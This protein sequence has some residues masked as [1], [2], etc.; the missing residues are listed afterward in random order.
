MGIVEQLDPIFKPKTVAIIGA[1]Y[2]PL[3]FGNWVT[4]TALRSKFQGKTY[5]VNPKITGFHNVKVY[6][7]I[8]DIPEKV[9]LVAI[10]V[11]ANIIPK[12]L[13]D[14]VEKG[15]KGAIIFSAGFREIGE[16][17]VKRE[18]EI[19]EVAK[20]GNIRIVGP[21]CMGVYNAAVGLNITIL[22]AEK[23]GEVG[24][25]TQSGGYGLDIFGTGMAKGINFSKFISVGDKI[26]VKDNEYLEYLYADPDTKVI[27]MYMEGIEKGREFFEIAK[28]ITQKKPIFAIKIGRTSAGGAAAKSHTGAMAGEDEIFDAAFKQAGIIRAY[29]VEELFDYVKAYLAQPLPKGNRVG[30]LVGS[31]GLGAAAVDKA[32]ELGLRVPTISE[33]NKQRLKEI[34]PEF[35]SYKNPIDFTASGSIGLFTNIDVLKQV[36]ADPNIDSWFFGFTGSGISGIDEI[37]GNFGPM[38]DQVDASVVMEGVN[39]P[40]VGSMDEDDKLIRPLLQK[41]F[42]VTLYSTPERA[43]RALAGLV[44][45]RQFLEEGRRAQKPIKLKADTSAVRKIVE[46]ALDERRADLTEVESKQILSAYQ[47]PTTDAYLAKNREEAAKCADKIGYPVVLKIVSPDIIHKSD[48][49]GVKLNLLNRNEVV[50]AFDQIIQNARKYK[51]KASILGVSVQKMVSQGIEVIVGIKDDPQFGP[52][53]MFGL[54]GILTELLKDFSL[55]LVPISWWEAEKMVSE[56]RAHQLLEGYR[57]Y[58]PVDKESLISILMSVSALVEQNPSIKEMDLNPVLSYPDGAVAVD[59]RIILKQTHEANP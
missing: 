44:K 31:G 45:Y 9:D 29:D 8:L 52:V 27:M 19:V 39:V 24:F 55:R 20:K 28:R 14:C 54:G 46:K 1:S 25:I 32:V 15:V 10:I 6:P 13:E 37:L 48:A 26:D 40:R 5:L 17:G 35:A 18:K 16:E 53:I 41:M 23:K 51:A 38:L 59:A 33:E 12:I 22:S 58:R 43:I 47:I 36:F 11:P 34:L 21:N 50:T 57:N 4:L 2:D 49:A 30:L 42:G 7:T 3:K 56:I